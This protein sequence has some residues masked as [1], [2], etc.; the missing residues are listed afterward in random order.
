VAKGSHLTDR[1]LA[2]VSE[3]VPKSIKK[4]KKKMVFFILFIWAGK[5]S[6]IFLLLKKKVFFFF[7]F[8]ILNVLTCGGEDLLV[9]GQH[10]QP[11]DTQSHRS[12]AVG[13]LQGRSYFF[14]F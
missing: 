11:R 10:G 8:A 4:K 3:L 1:P 5:M 13:G 6:S 7:F 9:F 12:E 2:L 14:Y